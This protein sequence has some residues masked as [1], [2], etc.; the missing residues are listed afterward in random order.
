VL[1]KMDFANKSK[2]VPKMD[3]TIKSKFVPTDFTN[4]MY[5]TNNIMF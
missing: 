5:C 4:M 1:L 3:H 2:F